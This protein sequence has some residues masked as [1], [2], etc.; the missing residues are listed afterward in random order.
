MRVQTGNNVGV[1]GFIITGTA[2]KHV[3]IRAIG[4]SLANSGVADVL[5]ESF[6]FKG[7]SRPRRNCATA[8]RNCRLSSCDAPD[9]EAI[10]GNPPSELGI[11]SEASLIKLGT[12]G[13]GS[14]TRI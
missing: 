3:L 11:V 7:Q 12:S 2:P 4:P 13:M 9:R 8:H 5:A 1:G 10:V 6:L 14:S